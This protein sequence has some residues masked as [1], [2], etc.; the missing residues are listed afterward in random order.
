MFSGVVI[1]I[2]RIK[3]DVHIASVCVIANILNII[4]D[5][6]RIGVIGQHWL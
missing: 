3:I 2:V 1:T 6:D 5:G 4:V